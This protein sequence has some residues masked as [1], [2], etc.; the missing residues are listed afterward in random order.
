[1]RMLEMELQLKDLTNLKLVVYFIAFIAS[2]KLCRFV[3]VLF[4]PLLMNWIVEKVLLQ[5]FNV[6]PS[7]VDAS[8]NIV[9]PSSAMIPLLIYLAFVSHSHSTIL[10]HFIPH[11]R[12]LKG[13]LFLAIAL[14]TIIS[15]RTIKPNATSSETSSIKRDA[16]KA[17]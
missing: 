15:Y 1:M 6:F 10:T 7:E 17:T 3:I 11:D 13:L 14:F 16:F 9:L 5:N 12:I 2:I 8:N 4:V